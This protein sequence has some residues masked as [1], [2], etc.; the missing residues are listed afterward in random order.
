M[1]A[2]TQRA[3][4]ALEPSRGVAPRGTLIVI[5][6]R[7]E[8]P[9]LYQRFG[10]RIAGDGYRVHAVADPVAE[11]ALTTAQ[12]SPSP[13]RCARTC[14]SDRT[15][16][17]CSRPGWSRRAGRRGGRGGAGR[18]AGCG[19]A[20]TGGVGPPMRRSWEAEL[21]ART[22]CPLV[23]AGWQARGCAGGRCSSRSPPAG[24]RS[25]T[26]AGRPQPVLGLHGTANP[27]SP[28]AAA[29]ER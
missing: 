1:T 12:V 27:V 24:G 18:T 8:A 14:W 6:G 25:R 5:P 20:A 11:P 29:R 19:D 16:A 3:T 26:W 15:P 28:L 22:A 10:R 23:A 7:G 4:A 21:A 13:P 9:D 2:T 17:R